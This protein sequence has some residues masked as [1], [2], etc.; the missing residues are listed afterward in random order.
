MLTRRFLIQTLGAAWQSFYWGKDEALPRQIELA[1]GPMKMVF[2]PDLAFLRYL[3]IGDA[4][5]LRGVYAAVRDRNW[6]TV[7]PRVSN[8][9]VETKEDSFRVE[10]DVTCKEGPIDFVWKG[11]ISGEAAGRVRFAMK[12]D[13]RSTFFRNRIGFCVLHPLKECAGKPCV[14]RHADGSESKG[15]FPADVS[16]HQPFKNLKAISHTVLPGVT[17]EVQFEGDIFEME[18]HRNWTD[19]NYKTYCTP[20]EKPFPVEVKQGDKVEQAITI[21]LAGKLPS[22]SSRFSIRRPRV[23]VAPT[24]GARALPHIGLGLSAN[25]FEDHQQKLL[26][27]LKPSHLRVD[28]Q[29]RD[30][31]HLNV[32]GRAVLAATRLQTPLEVVLH[33]TA[34]AE[35]ELKSISTKLAIARVARYAVFHDQEKSTSAKW[36]QLARQHLKNAPVGAGTNAYFAELNRERPDAQ[37]LDFVTFSLNPQVHAF[38]NASLVENLAAQADVIHSARSFAGGKPLIVSP[39]TFKPRFNPNATAGESALPPDVLPPQ[40]DP[41]QC[42]LFG[43]AWT[44]GSV[45]YLAEAGAASITYYETTGALG[46]V[47]TSAG[48]R[49][50]KQFASKPAMTFPLYHV[51][52]DVLEMQGAEAVRSAS[53]QPLIAESLYLRKGNQWRLLVANLSPEPQSI[54]VALPGPGAMQ[55]RVLDA[56]SFA[57]ATQSAAT[58]RQQS[59]D[60]LTP[61][62]ATVD[63]SLGAY[64][65][66]RLDSIG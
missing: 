5:I 10:F 39:V 13:A 16:P 19:A 32:L 34:K 31:D 56:D 3:R 4:E 38:D 57:A 1:A 20:L 43:A 47:E 26:I 2:E 30:P 48:T 60:K 49:W 62:G 12:G 46:V 14:V 22:V 37:A 52:A 64:A 59:G 66:A 55:L 42:S 6:G 65:V 27:A 41:R 18:D 21:Q 54:R 36:V 61:A 23:E 24:S 35:D 44:L 58:W 7:A 28:L 8:L 15:V 51:L 9:R 33:L 25:T 45:K 11:E 29:F 17:A 53:S 50:P 40:V 63:L